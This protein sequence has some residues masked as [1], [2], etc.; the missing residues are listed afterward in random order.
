MIESVKI[1]KRQSE[2]RQSLTGLAANESPSEDETRSMQELDREYTTN[3]TRYRSALIAEDGE[4]REAGAELETRSTREFSSLIDAF[5]MRQIAQHLD[6]HTALSGQTAEVVNELRSQGGYRGIPVPYL[7]LE[8]RAGETIAS[9]TVDPIQTRN[10]ID[11]LFPGSVAGR[12]G[13]QIVTIGSGAVEYPVVTSSVA[14]A[15]AAS[16]LGDVGGPAAYVTTDLPLT[17]DST[18][19]VTMKITRKS[20]KQSGDALEQAI[21]R[22]MSGAISAEMDR[23][24]TLGAGASGEPLGIITGAATYGITST[25]AVGP[26]AWSEFRAAITRFLAANAANSPG[27]VSVLIRPEVWDHMDATLITGTAVSEWDRFLSNVLAGNVTMTSNALAAPS[28]VNDPCSAL[29]TTKAGGVAPVYVGLWGA[30]DLIRDPYSD[31][32]SGGLRVT[33]LAT[34]DVTVARP[35]QLQLITGLETSAA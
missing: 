19:G 17:P 10:V 27:A 32:A 9:G 16:E 13:A 24:V 11:R 1:Q 20:M 23:V 33:A 25:A 28:G 21:R 22:D 29:L 7:A 12:I 34:M 3:E 26:A 5:E 6:E 15:W 2:I 35:S 18:L 8:Q 30:V 31:A 4:R 14:S